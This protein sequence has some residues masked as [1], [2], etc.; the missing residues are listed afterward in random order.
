MEHNIRLFSTAFLFDSDIKE[1]WLVILNFPNYKI[2]NK[3]KIYNI[4][5]NKIYHYKFEQNV[6]I[7]NSNGRYQNSLKSFLIHSF[8]IKYDYIYSDEYI[9]LCNTDIYNIYDFKL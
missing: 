9:F 5:R 2:S 7:Y 4:Y 3:H 8:Q 1:H 6:K